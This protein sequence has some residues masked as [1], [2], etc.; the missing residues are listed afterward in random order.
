MLLHTKFAAASHL[1]EGRF[2]HDITKWRKSLTVQEGSLKTHIT[3]QK[4]TKFR[5]PPP[6]KK[7]NANK[8]REHQSESF[9]PVQCVTLEAQVC[10]R[11]C[12]ECG[13]KRRAKHKAANFRWTCSKLLVSAAV[14]LFQ[15]GPARSNL[16]LR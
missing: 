6:K 15:T 4:R 10:R 7:Q 3:N 9:Q 13:G 8:K 16:D 5:S 1:E 11:N 2:W 14:V 12:K